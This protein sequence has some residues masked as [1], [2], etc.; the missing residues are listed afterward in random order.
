MFDVPAYSQLIDTKN[1]L[2]KER[3]CGIVALKMVFDY[4]GTKNST[5]YSSIA[6]LIAEGAERGAYLESVG[7]RHQGLA[8]LAREHG[9]KSKNYD[10]F[11][12]S[13]EKAFA[14]LRRNLTSPVIASI[15]LNLH[16]KKEGHLV[17]ITGI[18]TKRVY[19]NDPHSKK[20]SEILRDTS[21]EKFLK[22]WKRRI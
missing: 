21:I 9:F 11:A 4:W 10:W 15:H 6:A 14:R 8:E 5:K 19:Y 12:L 2:W 1:A 18:K 17:V 22:G 16:P 13:P 7:W 3:S 20:R